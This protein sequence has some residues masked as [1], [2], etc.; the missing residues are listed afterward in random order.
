MF[1]LCVVDLRL[2]QALVGHFYMFRTITYLARLAGQSHCR[3]AVLWLSWYPCSSFSN[4]QLPTHIKETRM[5]GWSFHVGN[6]STSLCLKSCVVVVLSN[7]VPLSVCL[8]QPSDLALT[9]VFW[10]SPQDPLSQQLN[11]VTQVCH[12]EICLTTPD[13]QFRLWVPY[14]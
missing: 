2:N 4:L 14:Y 7:G 6:K 5:Q 12:W 10:L 13:W 3:L 11:N 9:T 1:S 8:E